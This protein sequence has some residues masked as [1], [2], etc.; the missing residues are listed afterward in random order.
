MKL[1]AMSLYVWGE[2]FNAGPI[3]ANPYDGPPDGG[4]N[5]V[6]ASIPDYNAQLRA[7]V[8]AAGGIFVETR[9][10]TLALIASLSSPPGAHVGPTTLDG[11]HPNTAYGQ[12]LMSSRWIT[13]V[14][15]EP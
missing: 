7:S 8:E 13:T 9:A 2:L 4:T 5:G 11:L 12:P 3:Y 10:E 1:W 14:Q 15:I 6:G